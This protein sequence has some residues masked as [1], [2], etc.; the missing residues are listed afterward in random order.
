MVTG[1]DAM[2]CPLSIPVGEPVAVGVIVGTGDVIGVAEAAGVN[3]KVG[4]G[5]GPNVN[6][7]YVAAICSKTAD[8]AVKSKAGGGVGKTLGS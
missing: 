4:V 1:L 2:T 8:S 6:H 5:V 3:V 7:A